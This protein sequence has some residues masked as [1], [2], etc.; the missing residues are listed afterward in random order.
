MRAL[1]TTEDVAAL[2]TVKPQSVRRW[3]TRG[4]GPPVLKVGGAVRY[5]VED[6]EAWLE[7]QTESSSSSTSR[8]SA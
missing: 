5:R 3:R 2:L 4:Y 8:R 7:R 6:V 1:L